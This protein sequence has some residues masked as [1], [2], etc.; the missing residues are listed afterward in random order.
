MLCFCFFLS[1]VFNYSAIKMRNQ[2]WL[3]SVDAQQTNSCALNSIIYVHKYVIVC[4]FQCY[5]DNYNLIN[6]I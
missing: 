2:A 5:V 1:V 6:N 3:V 4:V